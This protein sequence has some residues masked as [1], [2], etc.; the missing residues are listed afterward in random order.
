MPL[1]G[2]APLDDREFARLMAPFA[3]FE[4]APEVAAAVSGGADSLC[5]AWLAGRWARARSG[6]ALGLIIDHELRAE[7]AREAAAAAENL[8]RFGL[9][10]RVLRWRGP[11]PRSGIQA[12]A[13]AARYALLTAACRE[14]GILH[15]LV[16]HHAGDQAETAAIRRAAGSGPAGLAGMAS[17]VERAGVRILR[18]LLPIVPAR[19]RATLTARGIAWIE[20]PSND[21]P[22]QTRAAARRALARSGRGP[23][24]AAAAR[25]AGVRRAELEARVARLLAAAARL[26]PRGAALADRAALTAAPDPVALAALAQIVSCIGGRRWPPRGPRTALALAALRGG[27]TALTLGGCRIAARG[28]ALR[29]AREAARIPPLPLAAGAEAHWDGRFALALRAPPRGAPPPWR[30]VRLDDRAWAALR[31]AA[32]SIAHVPP[33]LRPGLPVLRGLE[34]P[35][36]F[37]YIEGYAP[38][39]ARRTQAPFA[40]EFRPL[41]PLAGPGFA[42]P[43]ESCQHAPGR[44]PPFREVSTS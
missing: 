8:R 31:R 35:P 7:S 37:P 6:A 22:A 13:R 32:P 23:A 34:G 14:T 25:C 2:A 28:G 3:P 43:P 11:K 39:A 20:D 40:A 44:A 12:A 24:L 17:V 18:P 15:L 19:L 9:A 41:R 16:G 10:A 38:S 36:V 5:L 33:L 27:A 29:I 26:D 21:D 42:P 1:S 30:A 4:T